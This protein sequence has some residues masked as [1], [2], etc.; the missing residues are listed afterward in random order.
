MLRG[1]PHK[2]MDMI[3]HND[4]A[5]ERNTIGFGS[6]RKLH[7]FSVS[8]LVIQDFLAVKGAKG[9]EINR[10]VIGLEDTF[11]PVRFLGSILHK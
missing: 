9:N 6:G 4:I 10:R 1:D 3:R 8:P 11:K 2:T 5:P 7:E